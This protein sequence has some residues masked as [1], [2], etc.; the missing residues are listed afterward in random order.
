MRRCISPVKCDHESPCRQHN[1]DGVFLVIAAV[2][3]VPILGFVALNTDLGVIALTK[4][5]MQNAVDAAA[6]AAAQEITSAVEDV[7]EN[8]GDTGDANEIAVEAAKQMA[9]KVS[10]L[11]DVYVDP[12]RDVEFGKRVFTD[13]G[14]FSIL[15]GVK[16][17]NVVKVT[18]R[19]DNDSQDQPDAKLKLFFAPVMGH[20]S[21]AI[22][23]SA[24][25]FVEARDIAVVLDYS[26]SMND[27]SEF[28]AMSSQRLGQT[29]VEA[30]LDAI[31]NSL[32]AADPR[33]SDTGLSK[34]PATGLGQVDSPEGTHL[35]DVDSDDDIVDALGLT[36][37]DADGDPLYPFPQEGKNSDGTMKGMPSAWENRERWKDYVNFVRTDSDVANYGYHKKYGYRT[38]MG[39]L[40]KRRYRNT[41]SEDLWVT[42]HYP[43]NAMKN[44][45]TL[46]TEF[47]DE[48]EFGDHIGL[49]TYAETARI[50]SDLHEQDVSVEVDLGDNPITDDFTAI[51]TIQV[52]KQAGHYSSR[53]GMGYGIQLAAQLLQEHGR[54]GARPTMLLMTDGNTNLRPSEWEL[55]SDWDWTSLTDYD[56]DGSPDYETTN[57]DRQYAFWEAKQAID[58]GIV[59]HTLTVGANADR[60]LMQAIANASG[61]VW[62]DVPG[63]STIAEIESQMLTA[64]R[65]IAANVPPA[66]LLA[67]EN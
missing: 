50:E 37:T 28:R 54:Y 53:T 13:S 24:I 41:Q 20:D 6:L 33:F 9:A 14:S 64:F 67:D 57:V 16:P 49:V 30:N 47:L 61:G 17:F 36:D 43:F 63:G 51:D 25:A 7:G 31:W 15:W 56:G 58:A 26:G 62:I 42:P 4:S 48:L 5:R 23:A 39:Y 27:D 32:V 52:H 29:A 12:E 55:P 22:T 3:L 66:K 21:T 65:K 40:F 1:R 2:C 18:A 11:N 44:G 38:L 46:F 10:G 34:F 60:E 19:R 45:M 8:G 35:P 59:I